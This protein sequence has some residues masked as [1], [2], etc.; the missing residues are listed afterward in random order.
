MIAA[1]K[2]SEITWGRNI[3]RNNTQKGTS[4]FGWH[5]VMRSQITLHYKCVLYGQKVQCSTCRLEIP[6][7]VYLVTLSTVHWWRLE[8]QTVCGNWSP[9]VFMAIV[10]LNHC[11]QSACINSSPGPSWQFPSVFLDCLSRA[12]LSKSKWLPTDENSNQK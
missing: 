12:V 9:K 10:G 8:C 5:Q 4:S 7:E 3:G 6:Y 2:N 1:R 11:S